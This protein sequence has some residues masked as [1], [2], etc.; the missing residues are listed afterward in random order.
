MS[1]KP[2]SERQGL[3]L[4]RF[5]VPNNVKISTS[6]EGVGKGSEFTQQILLLKS[7]IRE[8]YL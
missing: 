1:A 8:L 4:S 5:S 6:Q 3:F 7:K 2:A